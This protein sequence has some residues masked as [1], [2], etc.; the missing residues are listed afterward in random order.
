MHLHSPF[1]AV[2]LVSMVLDFDL[3]FPFECDFPR[4]IC[5]GFEIDFFQ[6]E[7]SL[8]NRYLKDLI[9][10]SFY[11][12]KLPIIIKAFAHSRLVRTLLFLIPSKSGSPRLPFKFNYSRNT[13]C[14][15]IGIIALKYITFVIALMIRRF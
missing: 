5:A 2:V 11:C 1:N 9:D 10:F 13:F 3:V 7:N 15:S 14:V 4:S 8:F 12:S 6:K